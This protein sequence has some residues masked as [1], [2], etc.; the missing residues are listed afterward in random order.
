MGL[1]LSQKNTI[2]SGVPKRRFERRLLKPLWRGWRALHS[3]CKPPPR[4]PPHWVG[5]VLLVL[6]ADVVLATVVWTVVDFLR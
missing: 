2:G 3:R 1:V 4:K 6:A 5:I